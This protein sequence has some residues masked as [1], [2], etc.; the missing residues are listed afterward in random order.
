MTQTIRGPFVRLA[1][2]ELNRLQ[3]VHLFSE[4]DA[5]ADASTASPHA[6]DGYTEWLSAERFPALT[7]T[8]DWTYDHQGNRIQA[9]WSSLHTN[10]RVLD[11]DGQDM[12]ADCA[13]L[14]VARLLTRASWEHAVADAL[15]L[16][17][18]MPPDSRH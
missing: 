17:L 8:W 16:H 11:E 7:F 6:V 14:Y 1:V 2:E 18:V 4:F 5:P 3:L 13:L 9:H 10:L 15:N 12:T